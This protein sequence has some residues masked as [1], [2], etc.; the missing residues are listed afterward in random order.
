MTTINWED[1]AGLQKLPAA[2][3]V[4]TGTIGWKQAS[5]GLDPIDQGALAVQG[6]MSL[7]KAMGQRAISLPAA[8]GDL[9]L[10]VPG[11]VAGHLM[12]IG[13]RLYGTAIGESRKIVGQAGELAEALPTLKIPGTAIEIPLEGLK[14]P[15]QTIAKI[16]TGAEPWNQDI[17]THAIEAVGAGVEKASRGVVTAE[18]AKLAMGVAMDVA[19]GKGLQYGAKAVVAAA[20]QKAAKMIV[21]VEEAPV[22]KAA[23]V[24]P[25]KVVTKADVKKI[26]ADAKKA[27]MPDEVGVQQVTDLFE[28]AKRGELGASDPKLLAALAGL[29]IGAASAYA[30]WDYFNG[31]ELAGA[32]L[33]AGA[34]RF[35]GVPEVKLLSEYRAGGPHAQEAFSEIYTQTLPAAKRLAAK[36]GENADDILQRSYEK[37]ATSLAKSA[38]SIGGFRGAQGVEGEAKINTFL[39][40]IIE[41]E[42]KNAWAA[43]NRRPAGSAISLEEPVGE[44]T[45]GDI[46]SQGY[47]PEKAALNKT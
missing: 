40:R 45:L 20:K 5:T 4:T 30:L 31:P 1:A 46:L 21:P 12:N 23:D 37:L 24:E 33:M 36:F 6:P 9:I 22:P 3:T 8:T 19:G 13:T 27:G 35:K 26:F 7:V 10:G 41:N 2:S 16:T 28:K 29:G 17:I 25:L 38:E 44:G 11:M 39:H 47:G 32:A 18:D 14:T 43:E 34:T 15:L 42:G